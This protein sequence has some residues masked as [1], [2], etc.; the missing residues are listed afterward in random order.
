MIHKSQTEKVTR[1]AS[2]IGFDFIFNTKDRVVTVVGRY[3]CKIASSPNVSHIIG[4]Q[5][6]SLL[7]DD[8]NN[9]LH[10]NSSRQDDSMII[11]V[12]SRLTYND[13]ICII[14]SVEEQSGN[15]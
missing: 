9:Q 7:H 3:D 1:F 5:D 2:N 10:G 13:R 14:S 15:M 4:Y 11:Q 8:D 12:G 6:V